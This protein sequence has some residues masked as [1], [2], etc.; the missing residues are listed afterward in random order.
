VPVPA[1]RW[2]VRRGASLVDVEDGEV[3][4]VC[5]MPSDWQPVPPFVIQLDDDERRVRVSDWMIVAGADGLRAAMVG[6]I[7]TDLPTI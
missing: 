3:L 7:T 1:T 2:T 4:G 6:E 5:V